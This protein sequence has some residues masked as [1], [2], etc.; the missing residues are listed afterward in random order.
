MRR[1]A[2]LTT[3]VLSALATTVPPL[4]A[5]PAARAATAGATPQT[6]ADQLLAT[7]TPAQKE[8]LIRCD[9]GA[10]AG[11][12]IPALSIADASAGLRG[13][14]GVTAFPVPIAQAAT[15]DADRTAALGAAI[16]AEGRA[17]GY[18][19][20]LAPTVD[21][22]RHWHSGRQA[23]GM[24]E[25]PY[26]TGTL[27]A[28]FTASMQQQGVVATVKHFAAYTQEDNRSAVDVTV[29][30][31]A[32]HEVY[33]AP[34]RRIIATTP[35]TSVMMAYPKVNGT[36]AVQSRALFDDLKNTIGL[37]GH[38][39]PDFWAG[40]D[41][42]AAVRAGM[43]LVGLG[44]GGVQAPAGSITSG[45]GSA[46]LDDAA[47]RVLAT[48]IGAGLFDN[49]LPAP[50]ANVSTR[51]HQ[52]LAH[53]L[54]VHGTVLLRNENAVLPLARP[55]RIAVIG[56]AGTDAITGVSGSSYVDPGNWTTPLQAIRDRAG[57]ATT[58]TFAQGSTGDVP[59]PAVPATALGPGLT[60][61]YYAGPQPT[62][63]P[64]ATRTVSTI[65]FAQ[66]PLSGL[67][68]IWS[69]R[70]TGTLTPTSTGLHRFSLLPSGTASLTLG[71]T[72]V[73][74]GTR[75][76]ARFFLGPF[77]YPCRAPPPSPP[78]PPSPSRS[79]TPTPL[80]STALAASPSAGSPTP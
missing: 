48:M 20:L 16:G 76:M 71:G 24:G 34:F 49:P 67:P 78:A 61:S 36:F 6:R 52:D 38:T 57:S 29:S 80:P 41:Q 51:A 33:Q 74:S 66:A 21:L 28:T 8:A 47:R 62:G 59:L 43:D 30:D 19:N 25:D 68:P 75:H 60:V 4:A 15:F 44:P 17:K 3:A 63:T 54:A 12:G 11:L 70:W 35:L 73:V 37:Q 5:A 10:L 7:M 22:A 53:D 13:E 79:P 26:L 2:F 31:R 72:T 32:L 39:V 45:V 55:A 46:R 14:S 40:D 18:N 42:V 1:R 50:A 27:A 56:P 69:A 23:E 9:F 64:V 58:V 77:D 65:D